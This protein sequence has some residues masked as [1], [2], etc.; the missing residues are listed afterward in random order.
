MLSRAKAAKAMKTTCYVW[1]KSDEFYNNSTL[2]EILEWAKDVVNTKFI[3]SG[4]FDKAG[5]IRDLESKQF[6][7]RRAYVQYMRDNNCEP[8]PASKIMSTT[9]T[10]IQDMM[11][12]CV[13]SGFHKY[14]KEK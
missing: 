12:S 3:L 1:Y 4:W 5:F 10:N 2:E 9:S 6:G 13:S 8:I 14:L 7:S 11:N